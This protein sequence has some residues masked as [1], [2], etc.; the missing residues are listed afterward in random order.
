MIT[1]IAFFWEVTTC[2]LVDR[3]K[4]FGGMRCIHLQG[5]RDFFSSEDGCSKFLRNAGM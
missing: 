4:H 5:N 1:K 3:Y 2:S